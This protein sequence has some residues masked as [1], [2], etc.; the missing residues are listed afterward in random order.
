MGFALSLSLPNLGLSSIGTIYTA[1]VLARQAL[2]QCNQELGL[3]LEMIRSDYLAV[4]GA[5]P[6]IEQAAQSVSDAR[7]VLGL[8]RRRL[9]LGLGTNLEVINAQKDYVAALT[10][11]ADTIVESNLAQAKLL[12]DMGIISPSTLTAGYRDKAPNNTMKKNS[13]PSKP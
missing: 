12:H 4:I 6:Q 5:R 7:E 9:K 3:V 10:A 11:Q 1:R 8:A 13:N 2:Q